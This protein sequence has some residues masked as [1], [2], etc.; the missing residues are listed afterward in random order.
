MGG[1]L[2]LTAGGGCLGDLIGEPAT[3]EDR[4]VVERFG[5]PSL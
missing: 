5:A 1:L 3:S 4:A 2:L